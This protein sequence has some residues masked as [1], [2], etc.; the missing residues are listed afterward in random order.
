M[1][2][3]ARAAA[4][5]VLGNTFAVLGVPTGVPLGVPHVP[6]CYAILLVPNWG[7]GGQEDST[8]KI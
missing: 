4:A 5:V 8:Y 6:I 2:P 7:R 1:C 3:V